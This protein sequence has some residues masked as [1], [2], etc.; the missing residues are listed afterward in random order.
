MA[1]SG[2]SSRFSVTSLTAMVCAAMLIAS[3]ITPADAAPIMHRDVAQA[4]N[5]PVVEARDAGHAPKVMER[6]AMVRK[7]RR[8]E[9]PTW[10]PYTVL[11]PASHGGKESTD[12][13]TKSKKVYRTKSVTSTQK[14]KPTTVQRTT[15]VVPSMS[16]NSEFTTTAVIDATVTLEGNYPTP[17]PVTAGAGSGSGSGGHAGSG[18]GSNSNANS[19]ADSN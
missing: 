2:K 17:V 18:A 6:P 7:H 5:L 8:H 12:T 4:D 13:V 3:H 11:I 10:E 9:E 14:A 16:Y 15:T 1:T 19:G